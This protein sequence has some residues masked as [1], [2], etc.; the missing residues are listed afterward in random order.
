MNTTPYRLENLNRQIEQIRVMLS[1]IN[2]TL[3]N[4][5]SEL[6]MLKTESTNRTQINNIPINNLTLISEEELKTKLSNDMFRTARI[7]RKQEEED[8]S[9]VNILVATDGSV[10][11]ERERRTAA[12]AVI[13][14]DTSPLNIVENT[15]ESSSST[16]PEI[17]AIATAIEVLAELKLDKAIIM[18]DS[19]SAIEFISNSLKLDIDTKTTKKI[20][21]KSKQIESKI[22]KIRGLT[23][24]FKVLVL[25]HTKAHQRVGLDPYSRL[26]N[27]ADIKSRESAS[28]QLRK[29]FPISTSSV[30]SSTSTAN[31]DG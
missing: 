20:L 16:L 31:K 23:N 1:S 21:E 5:Q 7:I 19:T 30:N 17:L 11:T 15:N 26:N 14:S 22:F 6:D 12:F 24:Q 25:L 29:S 4:I 18:S 10:C 2:D 8:D 13:F 28:R 3:G 9:N 27:L